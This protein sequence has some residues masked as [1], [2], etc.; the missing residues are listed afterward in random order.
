[1]RPGLAAIVAF[2]VAVAGVAGG[3]T[4]ARNGYPCFALLAF[5]ITLALLLRSSARY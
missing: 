5:G 1:M 4:L 2:V 3:W